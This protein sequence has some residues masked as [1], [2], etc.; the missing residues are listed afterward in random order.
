MG[1]IRCMAMMS[2]PAVT[3]THPAS[4]PGNC[5][6]SCT[7]CEMNNVQYR[8]GETFVNP[9]S[10]CEECSCR[11]GIDIVSWIYHEFSF[12]INFYQTSLVNVINQ[13][14]GKLISAHRPST[15]HILF[16]FYVCCILDYITLHAV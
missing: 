1:R 12:N 6:P 9:V 7:M 11:V 16:S 4:R 8:N 15:G 10:V 2:C 14:F 3:C 13:S 5:C